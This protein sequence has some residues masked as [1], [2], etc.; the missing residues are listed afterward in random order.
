ML[1]T[2]IYPGGITTSQTYNAA[3]QRVTSTDENG[4]VTRSAYNAAG[5]LV[6]VTLA[7]GTANVATT[8]PRLLFGGNLIAPTMLL[9]YIL[10]YN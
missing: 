8:V 4:I 6:G 1:A 9:K 5:Q 10:A 7:D 2:T 3:G